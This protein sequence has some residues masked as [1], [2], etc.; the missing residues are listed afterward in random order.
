MVGFIFGLIGLIILLLIA[1]A[2]FKAS[3]GMWGMVL[4]ALSK[5]LY[6]INSFFLGVMSLVVTYGLLESVT[7]YAIGIGIVV[8]LTVMGL[9]FQYGHST[10]NPKLEYVLHIVFGL[11]DGAFVGYLIDKIVLPKHFNPVPTVYTVS[12]YVASI[13]AMVVLSFFEKK[14]EDYYDE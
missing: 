13:I 5:L 9:L 6:V 14:A 4:I 12:V 8:G 11:A 3:R 2:L 1:K 10:K 7:K